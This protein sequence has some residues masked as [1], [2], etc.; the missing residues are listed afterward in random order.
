M[1]SGTRRFE[2]IRNTNE[3]GSLS[4]SALI[5]S[6]LRRKYPLNLNNFHLSFFSFISH[7]IL[8]REVAT[9]IESF[10]SPSNGIEFKNTPSIVSFIRRALIRSSNYP[11]EYN[12]RVVGRLH[13]YI[14]LSP[15]YL[16]HTYNDLFPTLGGIQ[17][18]CSINYLLFLYLSLLFPLR[19]LLSR[20]HSVPL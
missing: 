20:V 5:K 6:T 2:I 3:C 15:S 7:P 18:E 11:L 13:S 1:P 17:P 16:I 8:S 9:V 10:S 14:Y 19:R 12:T 4:A